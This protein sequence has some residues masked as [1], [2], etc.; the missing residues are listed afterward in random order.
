[1]LHRVRARLRG[2]RARLVVVYVLV[3]AA[4]AAAGFAVFVYLLDKALDQSVDSDLVTNTATYAAEVTSGRIAQ[5]ARAP[6][7]GGS[8]NPLT[9]VLAVYNP[10][11]SLVDAEP[12]RLPADPA[13]SVPRAGY[14]TTRYGDRPF[15]FFRR[16]VTDNQGRTWVVIAGQSLA[17]SSDALSDAKHALYVVVPIAILLSGL[18]AWLLSGAALRPV[19]RMRAD[20]Q[21]LSETGA[22]GEIGGPGT[23]DSLDRLATTFNGLL[24][25]LHSSL[26]RQRE[27]VA[28]AGHELRTP[29]A[30][31]QT[32]LEVA[33]RPG[34]T[35][36]D[37]VDSIRHARA[38][39]ARLATLSEDLLLLAQT[40]G[41]TR[42]IHSELCE[43]HDIVAGSV[44]AR[45][46]EA[47]SAGVA[48]T[49]HAAGT[50][51]VAELDPVALRRVLDNLLTNALRHTAAGGSVDVHLSHTDD[52]VVI[53]VE[54]TGTGFPES[55]LPHAFERFSRA[56]RS[57]S[58]SHARYG[59]GLG[60]SIVETLVV[61]HGGT[62]T[63]ANRRSGGARLT[64]RL[65]GRPSA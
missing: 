1:V 39:A 41:P 36:E 12:V 56:E 25:R 64:V 15:R 29:L 20:A 40:D 14:V 34:R 48:L 16:S 43:P 33:D 47:E 51:T 13:G 21:Q 44:A 22:R 46:D 9:T 10:S 7:V 27:L 4:V 6:Q 18:G 17:T 11:N 19:E 62:V 3:A 5:S 52:D 57:R 54:D 50:P 31:L 8:Y 61:A 37:L 30:V 53:V 58:R 59:S 63:A 55:F 38:E 28:D 26:D 2:V 24:D 32:E 49:L 45:L 65:P 60:L 23:S 42:L 35:R